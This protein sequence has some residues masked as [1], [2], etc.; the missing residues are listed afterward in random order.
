MWNAL[1]LSSVLLG[2]SATTQPALQSPRTGFIQNIGQW[3]S[4]ALFLHK[5]PGHH[6]WVSGDA[7]T[8]QLYRIDDGKAQG[9]TIVQRFVGGTLRPE[10]RGD[11]P[12]TVSF[13]VGDRS[14]WRADAPDYKQLWA[15][16]LYPGI[17]LVLSLDQQTARYDFHLAPGA[18]PDQIRMKFE[19]VA[20]P[21][22]GP[23]GELLFQTQLGPVAHEQL[24]AY[25]DG[26]SVPVRFAIGRDGTVQLKLG[27]YDRSRPLL[28][29]P[30]FFSTYLGGEFYDQANGIAAHTDATPYVV[31]ATLSPN[32]PTTPGAFD[33]THNGNFD[34]F[35]CRMRPKADAFIFSTFLGNEGE[36]EGSDL[37]LDKAGF[38]YITGQAGPGF[39]TTVGA[40]DTTHNGSSDV[41]V[42]KL[43]PDGK[44][45]AYSTYLGGQVQELGM[46]IKVH[47]SSFRAYV[48]GRTASDPFPTTA[49]AFDTTYNGTVD[50]FVTVVSR[51][52]GSLFYSTYLGGEGLDN[53]RGIDVF[54]NGQ[55]T[56]TGL[57]QS[58]N[59]PT[60]AGAFD[61]VLDNQDAFVTR[62]FANGSGLEYSTLLGGK[63]SDTGN[64]VAVNKN[65]QPFVTGT[66]ES[67]NFPTTPGAF[68]TSY[69]GDLDIF[70][71]RLNDK[72][73]GLNYSTYVGTEGQENGSMVDLNSAS[74]AFVTGRT[75]DPKFPTTTT[76]FDQT[77]NGGDDCVL[78]TLNP[79][80][81]TMVY[82]TYYGSEFLDE[83]FDVFVRGRNAAFVAGVNA[84]N[85]LPSTPGVVQPTYQGG[86]ADGFA[87]RIGVP[88]FASN[89]AIALRSGVQGQYRVGYWTTENGLITGWKSIGG[90]G[91]EWDPVGFGDM[92]GNG[93]HDMLQFNRRTRQLGASLLDGSL[94]TGWRSLLTVGA[95]WQVIGTS[96]V[97]QNGV[98]D[99]VAYNATTRQFGCWFIGYV[100][101]PTV[102]GWRLL[103]SHPAGWEIFALD[104]V[105][106]DG[107]E[108]VLV[109]NPTTRTSG[110]YLFN[111]PT[112]LGWQGL[113]RIPAGWI[114]HGL[115]EADLDGDGDLLI[116][117][118]ASRKLGCY[119]MNGPT[120]TGWKTVGTVGSAWTVL[121]PEPLF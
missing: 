63:L 82:G 110:A 26:R 50:G 53:A 37:D 15:K 20:A 62:L 34:V 48:C 22:V 112:L 24:R 80:G 87:F 18:D 8:S 89:G 66:T 72:L 67:D 99:V 29:D 60:T 93:A 10:P 79:T 90:L 38:A 71:T 58:T 30:L 98:S 96:D 19:G 109:W 39:P 25:Q 49:G 85:G 65:N 78:F 7:L 9:H 45:L 77:H 83:G 81:A 46:D 118:T 52:G 106:G 28:I 6:L 117:Q 2:P 47:P 91:A 31:G 5:S 64:G 70:V 103:G 121:G 11:Y 42:T 107:S 4:K 115:L 1:L 92:D 14:K 13:F 69:N 54:T 95:A 32:F 59:F 44:T 104:D 101:D 73:S 94:I 100:G 119:L 23:S 33:T 3:D 88:L 41:F 16:N 51:D 36:D 105:N 55:A 40:F 43:S 74:Y 108:D 120:I 56:V 113:P 114:P 97:D 86:A 61:T 12:G 102:L 27:K 57:T 111:G 21:R 84:G 75:N 68:D 116:E 76:G 35:V 17:D